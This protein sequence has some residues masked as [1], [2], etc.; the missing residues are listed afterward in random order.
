MKIVIC[1][2]SSAIGKTTLTG[3]LAAARMPKAPIYAVDPSNKTVAQFGLKSK[4]YD[5][6]QFKE[7]FEEILPL[8]DAILDVGGS[9]I[10][11]N[12]ITKLQESAVAQMEFDYFLVPCMANEKSEKDTIT[13][14]S[15]L[16]DEAKIP[17]EKIRVIYVGVE[18]LTRFE[19]VPGMAQ[20]CGIKT[21]EIPF[22]NLYSLCADIGKTIA[23]V[24]ADKKTAAD[25]K[26]LALAEKN[27][28][29]QYKKMFNNYYA[30]GMAESVNKQLDQVWEKLELQ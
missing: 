15:L 20:A 25:Y 27:G 10:F 30:K 19:V 11:D 14:L 16:L 13:A 8:R 23:A 18:K 2:K 4:L 3:Q 29:E 1:N 9:Q 26:E 7:I 24:I 5:P 12:F 6:L 21:V 22:S 17:P 28:T